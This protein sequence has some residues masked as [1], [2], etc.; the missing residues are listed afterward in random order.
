M[1]MARAAVGWGVQ[2][3]AKKASV[4]GNTVTRIENGADAEAIDDGEAAASFRSGRDRVHRREW[5]RPGGTAEKAAAE[6]KGIARDLRNEPNLIDRSAAAIED[7]FASTRKLKVPAC[8]D[9]D[10]SARCTP[11]GLTHPSTQCHIS[12]D[13][14][15]EARCA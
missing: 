6:E 3:L 4:T 7:G 5:Q 12:R 9:A 13:M 11:S 10:R 8:V 2:E 1:N 15:F 14:Q